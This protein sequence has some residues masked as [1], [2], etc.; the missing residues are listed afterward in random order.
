M[1]TGHP[2]MAGGGQHRQGVVDVVQAGLAP[3]DLALRARPASRHL[4]ARAVRLE[5]P[6]APAASPAGGGE[7]RRS[8][9]GSSSPWPGPGPGPASAAGWMMSPLPGTVRTRWWN[10][11]WIWARSSK[12]SAWSNSRL[13]R[14]S[15]ARPVV[16]ELGALVE[17]GGVVLVR[18]DHEEGGR[19]QAGRDPEVQRHAADQEARVEPGVR[20]APR[21]ACWRW[22]SCRGCRPPPAPSA[23]AAGWP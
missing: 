11:R 22:W 17:E 2:G 1:A 20:P 10:W 19:A 13:F 5:Q 21:R 8:P 18:L 4:E 12:M 16:D 9:A 3:V 14:I 15:G 23:R 6:G 7:P